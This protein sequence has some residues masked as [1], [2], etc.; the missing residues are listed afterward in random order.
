MGKAW[1][2][3]TEVTKARGSTVK[4]PR[5][6]LGGSGDP[7]RLGVEVSPYLRGLSLNRVL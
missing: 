7:C 3:P 5:H 1:S 2:L 4:G 6:L